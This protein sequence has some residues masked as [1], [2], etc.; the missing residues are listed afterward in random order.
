M[1]PK[2]FLMQ[3]WL[4]DERIDMKLEEH[5]RLRGKLEAG[6]SANYSGM[7]RGG[8]GDWT[9]AVDA[10]I[11]MEKSINREI[12]ALCKIKR[13]VNDAID[14]VV[15]L[16]YRVLLEMRYRC[17][18]PWEVIAEKMGYEVRNVFRLHGKAL[19]KV[20]VPPEYADTDLD[21]QDT[22]R[23]YMRKRRERCDK[24]V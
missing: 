10:V 23:L 16:Q 13:D 7:P 14:A 22:K 18:M 19:V 6:R 12:K 4:I 21:T 9:D 17:Y 20:K 5:E 15:E 3:A 8:S 24:N 11:D 2:Q 1:T